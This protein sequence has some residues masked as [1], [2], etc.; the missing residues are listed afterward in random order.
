MS[1]FVYLPQKKPAYTAN[2]SNPNFSFI[3]VPLARDTRDSRNLLI[4]F[5]LFN[6]LYPFFSLRTLYNNTILKI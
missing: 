4:E 3:W 1:L 5:M 2:N 6:Y